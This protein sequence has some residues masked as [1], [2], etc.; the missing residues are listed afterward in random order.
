M[1]TRDVRLCSK[2]GPT[3]N[4]APLFVGGVLLALGLLCAGSARAEPSTTPEHD[5]AFK[6]GLDQYAH[7]NNVGAIATWE[8]LLTTLGEHRG[9][10]VLYNLGLAYQAIG[11]VTHAIE[12]YSAFVSE[13][14]QRSDVPAALA[15][16]AAD[17]QKR[18]EELE[19]THGAVEVRAPKRGGLVLTRVGT[20]EPRAAGYVVWLAPGPHDVEIFVGTDHVKRVRVDVEQGKRVE[21]DTS[22][23]ESEPPPP[24]PAP[25]KPQAPEPPPERSSTWIWI[26]AAATTTSLALPI[27]TFV[28]A[29][30]KKSDAES[31][32]IG[33]STYADTR[34][35]F[36]T[37]RTL[38]YV[39]YAVP[40]IL[41]AATVAY[42]VL[43]PSAT[44]TLGLTPAGI[45]ARATF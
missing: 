33:H 19:R 39:S 43:R 13:V 42:V 18:R 38:H 2:P 40:A 25:P 26:G 32:G 10:K 12:R 1:T 11:D 27:A 31:L 28:V 44:T 7:G 8:S 34:A 22:P 24:A 45:I 30:N 16:R 14:G 5:A 41:A 4:T 15:Q 3:A 20:G 9:Y 17:A 21:L 36:E 6:S 23:P 29:S 37:W 35:S